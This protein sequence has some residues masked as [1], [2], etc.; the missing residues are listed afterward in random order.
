MIEWRR[1]VPSLQNAFQGTAR[2]VCMV[3]T[4]QT[5]RHFSLFCFH[6][7]FL[8]HP[9]RY[10]CEVQRI[11]RLLPVLARVDILTA[12]GPH[13]LGGSARCMTHWTEPKVSCLSPWQRRDTL[14]HAHVMRSLFELRRSRWPCKCPVV[15]GRKSQ[16]QK[17][18]IYNIVEIPK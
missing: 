14:I 8:R 9:Q 2:H 10:L 15:H 3:C 5:T 13:S 6:G 18:N 1:A 7:V 12:A 16:L 11:S 4:L 17:K